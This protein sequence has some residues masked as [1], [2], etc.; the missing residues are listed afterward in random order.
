[1]EQSIEHYAGK[2][3]L[4]IAGIAFLMMTGGA[5][6]FRSFYAVG[7]AMGVVITSALNIGKVYW[8]KHTVKRAAT[9]S[10][11]AVGGYTGGFYLARFIV[12]GLVLVGSFYL[13]MVD[14]LGAAI[15]LLTLP[16]AGYAVGLSSKKYNGQN[17]QNE[18]TSTNCKNE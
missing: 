2:M 14:M 1:M 15:G 17:F 4:A 12:T 8:L 13:P 10:P 11:N 18:E 16:I 9:L 3:A 6:F 5:V 7:F